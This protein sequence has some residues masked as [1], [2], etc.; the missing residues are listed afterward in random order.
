MDDE[1]TPE[2]VVNTAH[3]AGMLSDDVRRETLRLIELGR[4]VDM[5]STPDI[6]PGRE[7]ETVILND[8]DASGWGLRRVHLHAKTLLL[9]ITQT[10]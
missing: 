3:A 5:C 10:R 4:R 1:L 7:G 8:P 2:D 9:A 6:Y